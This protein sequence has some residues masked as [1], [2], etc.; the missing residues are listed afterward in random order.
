MFDTSARSSSRISSFFSARIVVPALLAILM[1]Q[2]Q[3]AEFRCVPINP[4][5]TY[6]ACAVMDMNG[7]SR[8]DILCGAFW[9]E[10]PDWTPHEFRQVD[11]IRGRFDDYSNLLLDVN[12]DG[13]KDLISANYRSETIY[14]IQNPGRSTSD[15]LWPRHVV[16]KPGPM[17]TARLV[18][19]D[20]DGLMDLLPNGTKFAA[21]WSLQP[22]AAPVWEQHPLPEELAGHGIGFGDLNGDGRNDIAGPRGWAEAPQDRRRERWA[23]HPEYHL[24]QDASIP[25]LVSDVDG[26]GD[27]DLIWGRGHRF[28]IYWLEQNRAADGSRQWIKHAIDTS[29]SQAH[30]LLLADLDGDN[31]PELITGSRYMGHEGKDPGE[32]NPLSVRAYHF[33]PQA[34]TWTMQT[35][36]N[37]PETGFD[38]D[39]KAADVD[40]DSDTDLVCCGRSGLFLLENLLANPK[41]AAAERHTMEIAASTYTHS[42]VMKVIR[43]VDGPAE[44]VTTRLDLGLR[45]DHILRGMS[46]AMGP[47]PD[48]SRRIPLDVQVESE[49]AAA[50]YRRKRIS[51][52]AETGDRVPAFLLIPDHRTQAGPAMLCLHQTTGIGKGEPAGTG[53][54]PNLHYA[55]EL[56]QRGFVCLVPDYPSFG[57]YS[58]DFKTRGSHYASGSMKA[59]WNNVRAVDLLESL[60]EVD[61]DRIGCIG[62]SL[63]GHNTL[64]TAAFDGRLRAVV[65]SCGFTAFHDYYKGDLR[66]WTS[67]R[68]M[69]RIRDIYQNDPDQVPFDFHEVLAAIA[70][71]GI[72]INAP[73]S[74][75]NFEISG[76]KK[77]VAEATR[78]FTLFGRPEGIKAVYPDCAHDF[79]PEVR[80]EAY[81]WLA[82]QL[83]Q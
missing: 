53:G 75:S 14:W 55:H 1:H 54:L 42:D 12:G 52:A 31:V 33:Q 27:N 24:W 45:R 56:A 48:S 38:L 5:S 21:W 59:I 32:Y 18:D 47:L 17:E 72:F 41:G 16:A 71:R 40:G 65:T 29:F 39:P 73:V 63:G 34:R 66:G 51:F 46:L 13:A 57:D 82:E 74:D 67:D 30:S 20:G 9:Y 10:S 26:D 79:P 60:P 80:Q 81:D 36:S 3:A 83:K 25:I 76:V 7:D 15:R 28:G 22:A 69:P 77:V 8:P 64:F 4:A 49:E 44:E 70:P 23:F 2:L 35:L 19:V 61:P 58:Y 37:R 43:R 68:Y 11:E 62:H 6:S 50:G 78:A